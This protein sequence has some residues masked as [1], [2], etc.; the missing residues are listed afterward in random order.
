MKKRRGLQRIVRI[1]TLPVEAITRRRKFQQLNDRIGH[2]E[3]EILRL[4][5]SITVTSEFYERR[6]D[7]IY[8]N[9]SLLRTLGGEVSLRERE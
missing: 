7:S 6:L 9:V 1:V 3:A 8:R 4:E 2:L 5:R